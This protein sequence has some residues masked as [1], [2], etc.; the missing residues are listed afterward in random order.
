M[1]IHRW[2]KGAPT[3]STEG[4]RIRLTLRIEGMSTKGGGS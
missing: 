2:I 4:G 3:R 1:M